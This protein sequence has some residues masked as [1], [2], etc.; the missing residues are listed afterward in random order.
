MIGDLGNLPAY[1]GGVALGPMLKEK[2]NVPVFIN[3]DADLFALGEAMEGSLPH[4]NQ[5]LHK[6]GSQKSYQ[7][8]VGLTLGTGFGLGVVIRGNLI[9]G[10]N[11]LPNE[12]W[13][14]RNPEYPQANIEESVSIRGI[15][16]SFRKLSGRNDDL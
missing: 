13:L 5:K 14:M 9:R 15:Q 7:N 10:D 1:R 3:N 8:L 2:F 11:S 4:L 12:I 6:A 16:R